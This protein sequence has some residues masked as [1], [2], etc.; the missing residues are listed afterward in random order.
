MSNYPDLKADY[1]NTTKKIIK[2]NLSTNIDTLR[3]YKTELINKYNGIIGYFQSRYEAYDPN[4][5]QTAV[6]EL[7]Y[8][9]QKLENCLI[10]LHCN[11]EIAEAL[12]T[13]IDIDQITDP[14]PDNILNNSIANIH[15][16]QPITMAMAKPEY[17]K[18]CAN[19]INK[20]FKGDPLALEAFCNSIDLLHEVAPTDELRTFLTTFVKSKLEG[21]ALEAIP[22]N[23]TTTD[24][25][26]TALRLKILPD[27]SKIIE[28][29]M[30]ALRTSRK[31]MQEYSKEAEELAEALQR[32]LIVEGVPQTKAEQMAIERTVDMCRSSA[33]S[34]IVKS[35]LAS[36]QFKSAKEA[37]AKFV[38]ET[39]NATKEHQILSYRADRQ[40]NNPNNQRNFRQNNSRIYTNNSRQNPGRPSFNNGR[41]NQNR[42]RQNTSQNNFQNNNSNNNNFNRQN[43]YHSN[44]QN[45]NNFNNNRNNN[46]GNNRNIRAFGQENSQAPQQ[47]MLGAQQTVQQPQNQMN[48]F[49]F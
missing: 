21:K 27:N 2:T 4:A 48:P 24:E 6:H 20:N 29:K 42:F 36:S 11:F 45:G 19:T 44:N 28:G 25:I 43:S 46:Y 1:I 3:G 14:I 18:L 30:Q 39:G 33:R 37:V 41:Q 15:P 9:R 34:D 26:K 16:E 17:L 8:V 31:S 32:S 23:V 38:I 7:N 35:I 13:I 10:R 5:K 49:Q 12:F 22:T 47:T 40:T